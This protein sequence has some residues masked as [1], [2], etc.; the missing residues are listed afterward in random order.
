MDDKSE[1]E[2]TS[3]VDSNCLQKV[4]GSMISPKTEPTIAPENSEGTRNKD[5]EASGNAT[6]NCKVGTSVEVIVNLMENS[7]YEMNLHFGKC[8]IEFLQRGLFFRWVKTFV[9]NLYF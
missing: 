1:G 4:A 8:D 2:T 6:M 9:H 5:K 7:S 3:A